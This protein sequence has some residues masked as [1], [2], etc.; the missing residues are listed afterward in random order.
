MCL[1]DDALRRGWAGSGDCT[2][3]LPDCFYGSGYSAIGILGDGLADYHRR[4]N[5]GVKWDPS[6]HIDSVAG[7]EALGVTSTDYIDIILVNTDN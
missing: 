1:Q 7:A 6:D 2:E 3:F 5:S 4:G